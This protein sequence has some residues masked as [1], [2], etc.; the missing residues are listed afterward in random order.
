MKWV[1]GVYVSVIILLDIRIKK[2]HKLFVPVHVHNVHP[3]VHLS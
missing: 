3:V 2:L 1:V